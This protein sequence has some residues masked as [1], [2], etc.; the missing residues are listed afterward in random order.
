[1]FLVEQ[2]GGCNAVP[3]NSVSAVLFAKESVI[4]FGV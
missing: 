2:R 4:I 3:A 1:M